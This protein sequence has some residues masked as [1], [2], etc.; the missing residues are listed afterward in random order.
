MTASTAGASVGSV[1]WDRRR[2]L[3]VMVEAPKG[4]TEGGK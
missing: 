4:I 2:V 1:G 3:V